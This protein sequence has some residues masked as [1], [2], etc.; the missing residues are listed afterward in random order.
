MKQLTTVIQRL[1]PRQGGYHYLFVSKEEV[2][3]LPKQN[4]TRLRCTLN[5]YC[6]PCGLNHLGDGNFF[7]ILGKEKMK[8]SQ[9]AFGEE[10][11]FSIEEDPNPLGV[12]VPEVL[13]VL[14]DQDPAAKAVY[15]TLTEGKKRS[16]IFSIQKVKNMDLQVQKILT[17]LEQR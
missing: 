3:L 17:F 6:F 13:Q 4:K 14:L 7:I 9:V 5:N 1:D 15:D 16:L 10:V 2:A 12:E 8:K 11:H